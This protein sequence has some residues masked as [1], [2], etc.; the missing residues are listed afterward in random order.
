M[1]ARLTL[2]QRV[3]NLLIAFDQFA[4]C[5]LCLGDSSPEETASSVAWQME[6]DRR[7]QG[8]LFRP[9]IDKIFWFDP[10]HCRTSYEAEMARFDNL[11]E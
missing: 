10:D 8:H 5:V 7:W 6:R 11:K 9:I 4:F 3:L 2:R 1:G